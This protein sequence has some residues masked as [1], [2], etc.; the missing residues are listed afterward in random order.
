MIDFDKGCEECGILDEELFPVIHRG[1]STQLC[2]RCVEA[3]D[4]LVVGQKFERS[5]IK[6]QTPP[7]IN[8][9]SHIPGLPGSAKLKSNFTLNDL[10]DRAKLL[11]E[12]K[13]AGVLSEN[14]FL[15]DFEKA[16]DMNCEEVMTNAPETAKKGGIGK[17]FKAIFSKK[18][19]ITADDDGNGYYDDDDN[20]YGDKL[21]NNTMF[22]EAKK[23]V[24]E[25][26]KV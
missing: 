8:S 20:D 14:E 22:E 19:R 26:E 12:K 3:N 9:P 25:K 4:A 23:A 10:Y 16:K 5:M 21:S 17:F 13:K 6:P 24:D 1:K 18:P 2:R 15:K 7:E 11:K